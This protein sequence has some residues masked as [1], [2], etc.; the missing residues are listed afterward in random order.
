MSKYD[1]LVWE[2]VSRSRNRIWSAP[3]PYIFLRRWIEHCVTVTVV[4]FLKKMGDGTKLSVSNA[5]SIH[6]LHD[7][8]MWFHIF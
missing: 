5:V 8:A 7:T 2:G 6:C 3:M 4:I 1:D